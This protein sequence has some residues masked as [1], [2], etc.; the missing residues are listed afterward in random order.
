MKRALITSVLTSLLVSATFAATNLVSNTAIVTNRCA[1][2]VTYTM[3]NGVARVQDPSGR[4][5][6]TAEEAALRI[7]AEGQVEIASAAADAAGTAMEEWNEFIRTNDTHVLYIDGRFGQDLPALAPNLCGWVAA[8]SFDGTNDHYQIW[9]NRELDAP[10]FIQARISAADGT[11]WLDATWKDWTQT[12]YYDRTGKPWTK[13]YDAEVEFLESSGTQYINTD[14]PVPCHELIVPRRNADC[15]FKTGSIITLGGESGFDADANR[16]TV[17]IGD[18]PSV[19]TALQLPRFW[20]RQAVGTNTVT[21]AY[22]NGFLNVENG[23]FKEPS[24]E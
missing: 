9:F 14:A 21:T 13:P 18:V 24:N 6:G 4:I 7:A 16:V 1:Q 5:V 10:P 8:Q 17:R 22:T 11:N 19:T 3:S 23:F 15:V 12:N 2:I 20:T